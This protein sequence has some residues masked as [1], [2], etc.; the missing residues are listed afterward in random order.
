MLH[1]HH[2]R[3]GYNVHLQNMALLAFDQR[4]S[5]EFPVPAS[6]Q[7]EQIV[8]VLLKSTQATPGSG[9]LNT[10]S[11]TN[12]KNTLCHSMSVRDVGCL[13]VGL[14]VYWFVC[15][16]VHLRTCFYACVSMF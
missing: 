6:M 4:N 14:P 7:Q 5:G 13:C 9:R 11:T 15:G 3:C 8:V 2:N 16:C 10:N 12:M 1:C